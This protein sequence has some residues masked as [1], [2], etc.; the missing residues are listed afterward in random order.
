[1]L[2]NV[3]DHFGH[4]YLLASNEFISPFK[5]LNYLKM[6]RSQSWNFFNTEEPMFNIS[7]LFDLQC[8]QFLQKTLIAIYRGRRLMW[9]LIMFSVGR[10]DPFY[11]TPF[12]IITVSHT[13]LVVNVIIRLM[14]SVALCPNVITLSGVHCNS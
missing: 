5:N 4:G 2:G 11:Q 3:F 14:L 8:Y 9:S 7:S 12:D 6:Y 13:F 1:M 10:S